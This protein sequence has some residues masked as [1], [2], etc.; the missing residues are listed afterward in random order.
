M[1]ERIHNVIKRDRKKGADQDVQQET[2][3]TKRSK[4]QT[5]LLSRYPVTST[6][7]FEDPSV[8]EDSESLREHKKAMKEEMKKLKPRDSLLGPLM[9]STY[10]YRRDF[11]LCEIAPV[12]T[13]ID[14]FPAIIRPSMVRKYDSFHIIYFLYR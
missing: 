9:K 13:V 5:V 6:S 8:E 10:K 11:I 4:K 3:Q 14:E 1:V 2:P 7:S 12:S